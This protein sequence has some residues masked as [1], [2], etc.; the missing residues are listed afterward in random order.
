[1][2][3]P[4]SSADALRKVS[5]SNGLFPHLLC[6]RVTQLLRAKAVRVQRRAREEG[7]RSPFSDP[8]HAVLA[9]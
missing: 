7:L 9:T 4:D 2:P 3:T 8:R 6:N 1:M 5:L